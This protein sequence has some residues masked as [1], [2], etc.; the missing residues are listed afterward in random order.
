MGSMGLF[1]DE[2]L[3]VDLDEIPTLWKL[4]FFSN[5]S[6]LLMGL[7]GFLNICFIFMIQVSFWFGRELHFPMESSCAGH[8][9]SGEP[10][11]G[12][13]DCDGEHPTNNSQATQFRFFFIKRSPISSRKYIQYTSSKGSRNSSHDLEKHQSVQ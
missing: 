4:I 5:F 2:V 11:K 6:D 3:L 1:L 10:S 7:S 12:G 9:K 8:P 13:M